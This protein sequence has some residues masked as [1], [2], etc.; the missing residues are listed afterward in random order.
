MLLKFEFDSSW[1]GAMTVRNMVHEATGG[2]PE[3]AGE[4]FTFGLDLG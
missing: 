3:T 4:V 1:Y 2:S